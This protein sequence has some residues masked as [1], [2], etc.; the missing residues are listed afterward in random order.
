VSSHPVRR[1]LLALGIAAPWAWFLVRDAHP[2]LNAVAVLLPA[3]AIGAV[4][5]LFLLA[6][7][8]RSPGTLFVAVSVGAMAV[9]AVLGPRVAHDA[10]EPVVPITIAFA[11][12]Y[13]ENHAPEDAADDLLD[14][15]TDLIVAVEAT[16]PFREAIDA[17]DTQRPY[18]L[19]EG[20]LLL[21]SPW[22]AEI[23][24]PEPPIMP[25]GRAILVRVLPPG[26]SPVHVLVVHAPNPS[27]A[28]TF[29]AQTRQIERV[30]H[31]VLAFASAGPVVLVGDLNLSDRT[32]AYRSLDASLR[33]VMRAGTRA[34][35][36]YAGGIW[37]FAML[38]IDHLFVDRDWCASEPDVFAVSGS[39]HR[40]ILAT[41][42][43]C[44]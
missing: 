7:L 4:V 29:A 24:D 11:N 25:E 21:H 2:W 30:Q 40:G 3:L 31:Y 23:V 28:T 17:A 32:S 41:I 15:G 16:E 18:Q 37:R 14:R 19:D 26:V 35:N 6:G 42:G 36:T 38:R 22:P 44:P 13:D 34:H 9:V 1:L 43:P 12:V 20:Q 27:S 5:V 10:V 8:L 39:D 33:D